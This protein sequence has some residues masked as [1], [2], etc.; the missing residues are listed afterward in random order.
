M[1]LDG[2]EGCMQKFRHFRAKQRISHTVIR[3]VFSV[4]QFLCSLTLPIPGFFSYSGVG[5]DGGWYVLKMFSLGST[6]R[7]ELTYYVVIIDCQ[8]VPILDFWISAKLQE[9][10][11]TE[12]K[13]IK[14]TKR[15]NWISSL[16][17]HKNWQCKPVKLQALQLPMVH[18]FTWHNL[19][20]LL[21]KGVYFST[22]KSLVTFFYSLSFYRYRLDLTLKATGM[23]FTH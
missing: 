9:S 19:G 11:K 15:A 23:K 13:V 3:C 5:R 17:M 2:I 20:V 14:I 16:K 12:W 7:S 1:F 22:L 18:C 10:D 21:N 8:M 4:L 6:R